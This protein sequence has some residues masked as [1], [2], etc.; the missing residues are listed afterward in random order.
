MILLELLLF[1]WTSTWIESFNAIKLLSIFISFQKESDGFGQIRANVSFARKFVE[2]FNSDIHFESHLQIKIT[3]KVRSQ[4]IHSDAT[5][6]RSQFKKQ[7]HEI[8]FSGIWEVAHIH[9]NTF[10]WTKFSQTRKTTT[11]FLWNW[12]SKYF[13][14]KNVISYVVCELHSIV[15]HLINICIPHSFRSWRKYKQIEY[16]LNRENIYKQLKT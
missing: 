2:H 8:I 3:K 6:S 1:I 15:S 14:T 5:T 11:K 4:F 9:L 10:W 7:S 13:G 12:P 16:N